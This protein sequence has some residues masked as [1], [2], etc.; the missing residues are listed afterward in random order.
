M[1]FSRAA[2][3]FARPKR[4]PGASRYLVQLY[5]VA[6][7]YGCRPMLVVTA[8]GL[9]ASAALYAYGIRAVG[10]HERHMA[11]AVGTLLTGLLLSGVLVQYLVTT[12]TRT[13]NVERQ[14]IERSM[15]YAHANTAFK[16]RWPS[17][18]TCRST[19]SR[20]KKWMHLASSPAESRTTSTTC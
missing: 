2:G 6:E 5:Q 10:E 7:R 14:V 16:K 8:V 13:R 15:E 18:K 19:S 9:L 11:G 1:A 3:L 20:R 12:R 17:A 4:R